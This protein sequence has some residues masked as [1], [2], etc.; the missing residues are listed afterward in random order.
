MW[1]YILDEVTASSIAQLGIIKLK[2]FE[3]GISLCATWI[4]HSHDRT[5]IYIG[6]CEPEC[7]SGI[8]D[9][10]KEYGIRLECR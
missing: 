6:K 9:I 7:I 8:S 10:I 2:L 3:R 4:D 1:L 5:R